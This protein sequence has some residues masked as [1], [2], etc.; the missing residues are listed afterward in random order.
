MKGEQLCTHHMMI[1]NLYPSQIQL[2]MQVS[3]FQ[4][5]K[6]SIKKKNHASK[7]QENINEKTGMVAEITEPK[8]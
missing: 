8:L 6:N 3:K 5:L 7:H 1:Q 2:K 4:E